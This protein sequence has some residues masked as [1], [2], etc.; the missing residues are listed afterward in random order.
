MANDRRF[1]PFL[2]WSEKHSGFARVLRLNLSKLITEQ[3]LR[4]NEEGRGPAGLITGAAFLEKMIFS[5]TNCLTNNNFIN[6]CTS[7]KFVSIPRH[8]ILLTMI[9]AVNGRHSHQNLCGC[10]HPE[11]SHANRV[12]KTQFD[13]RVKPKS[14]IVGNG[15]RRSGVRYELRH[16][17]N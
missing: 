8:N 12:V 14:R 15:C 10:T 16:V 17:I 13:R 3:S 1:L 11:P 2:V 7:G 4:V 6:I 5:T 9:F